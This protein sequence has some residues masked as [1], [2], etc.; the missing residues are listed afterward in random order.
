MSLG[1]KIAIW[2]MLLSSYS[3]ILTNEIVHFVHVNFLYIE[4]KKKKEA[5]LLCLKNANQQTTL[6][7]TNKLFTV[8]L[9]SCID[10]F[11]FMTMGHDST[12]GTTE[13][14]LHCH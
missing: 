12:D 4:K 2:W 11:K 9:R 6:K 8:R 1:V 14:F 3:H 10:N 7:C 5:E 13:I